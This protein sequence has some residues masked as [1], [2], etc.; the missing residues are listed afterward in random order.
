MLHT[1]R[2]DPTEITCASA[3][4]SYAVFFG[5]RFDKINDQI[6]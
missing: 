2:K 4:G 5:A 1:A 3:F 6:R